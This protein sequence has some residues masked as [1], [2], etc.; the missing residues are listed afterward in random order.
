MLRAS[1]S[2]RA[3]LHR[4]IYD[5]FRW[6]SITKPEEEHQQLLLGT[7]F[8]GHPPVPQKANNAGDDSFEQG[9]RFGED[10]AAISGNDHNGGTLE[11]H[12]NEIQQQHRQQQQ[13]A[14]DYRAK[15]HR[16]LNVL[17]QECPE[18]NE[19]PAEQVEGKPVVEL[20]R[21]FYS[22][23][24][25]DNSMM[26]AIPGIDWAQQETYFQPN[27]DMPLPVN[28]IAMNDTNP[29]EEPMTATIT[30][31]NNNSSDEK[32]RKEPP[33]NVHPAQN[34]NAAAATG[35]T[36]KGPATAAIQKMRNE[37]RKANDKIERLSRA[38]KRRKQCEGSRRQKTTDNR[39]K[40]RAVSAPVSFETHLEKLKHFQKGYGHTRVPCTSTEDPGLARWVQTIRSAYKEKQKKKKQYS[41]Q[42]SD[43][44]VK[45]LESIGFEWSLKPPRVT[46][47]DRFKELEEYKKEHG[48]CQVVRSYAKNP[49]LG[50]WCHRQRFLAHKG[51]LEEYKIK[52]LT[53]LGFELWSRRKR[54]TWEEH[55]DMLV[56]F[57]RIHGHL[58]VPAPEP[59]S[60]VNK[61]INNGNT[62]ANNS[63][64]GES[65]NIKS[66]NKG[67]DEDE[68]DD[69]EGTEEYREEQAFRRWVVAQ[70]DNYN[71]KWKKGIQCN[72]DKSRIKKLASIGFDWAREGGGEDL[73][74]VRV[75]AAHH[76]N[77]P[78]TWNKRY[79]E[80]IEYKK[81][82]GGKKCCI[83][84]ECLRYF[85]L[86]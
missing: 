6:L 25:H 57:R 10:F 55:F 13:H 44:R 16:V 83:L 85:C 52:K 45:L 81:Q 11:T 61:V 19:C 5:Y 2:S 47:E 7:D 12:H 23:N 39:Q 75:G 58:D 46:W 40:F 49:P 65:A 76:R 9:R 66:H 31:N 1:N 30:T 67:E 48:N 22:Y 42:L 71:L 21:R 59:R 20:E 63:I 68:D 3:P 72:L 27:D 79:N 82:Y 4:A 86:R 70:R 35:I 53:D 38:Q 64:A 80:L 17:E 41:G 28:M 62:T 8:G 36:T 84:L 56:D 73:R 54:K 37:L 78:E 26:P 74:K 50:E 29:E 14:E 15:I 33:S 24:M 32:K 69:I 77:D 34:N 51:M 18:I 60:K 43:E